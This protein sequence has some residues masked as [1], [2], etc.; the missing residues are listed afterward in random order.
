MFQPCTDSGQL[1]LQMTLSPVL[2][3]QVVDYT[4]NAVKGHSEFDTGQDQTLT[5]DDQLSSLGFIIVSICVVS[6][7]TAACCHNSPL[8]GG[9]SCFTVNAMTVPAAPWFE[10]NVQQYLWDRTA[11]NE[12]DAH[13]I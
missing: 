9:A 4:S 7:L 3:T 5:L 6:S 8:S 11:E 13:A 12:S 1:R 2:G 10:L